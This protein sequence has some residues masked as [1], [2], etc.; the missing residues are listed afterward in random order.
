MSTEDPNAAWCKDCTPDNCI[1]CGMGTICLW[2]DNEWCL[3]EDLEDYLSLKS[4]DY[5]K[6]RVD[7]WTEDG[8]PIVDG[9]AI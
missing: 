5:R 3:P 1:G 7:Y 4:D 9:V 2:P 8:G 6:V